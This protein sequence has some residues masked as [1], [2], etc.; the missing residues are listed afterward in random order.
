MSIKGDVPCRQLWIKLIDKQTNIKTERL[1]N[2]KQV[3][4]WFINI[5]AV[6]YAEVNNIKTK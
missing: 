3:F 5:D 4:T 2:I 1:I 6:D